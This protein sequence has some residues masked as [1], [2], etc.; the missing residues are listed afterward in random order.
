MHT[1]IYTHMPEHKQLC[2][3]R[4][5]LKEIHDIFVK[6]H[7][8]GVKNYSKYAKRHNWSIRILYLLYTTGFLLIHNK[9]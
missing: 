1:Y 7:E 6:I 9:L 5:T 3:N 8:K 4:H 2:T